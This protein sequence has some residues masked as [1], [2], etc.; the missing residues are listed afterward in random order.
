MIDTIIEK[1]VQYLA[2]PSVV[3]HESFFMEFLYKD[4]KSL[5][6]SAFKH[7]GV[8]EI[9]GTANSE[10]I[11]CAHIDRHGLISLGD[12][13]Y[14]YAAQ[15]IKEIKYGENNQS[16]R[17]IMESIAKR[18]E[19]EKIYAYHP[20]TGKVLANGIIE[21]CYPNMR[22]DDALFY[23]EG[24]AQLEQNIPLAY[25]RQASY[26][27]GILKGQ[28]DNVISIAVIYALFKAGYQGT[29]LLTCEEEIGKS[30]VHIARHLEG[31]HIETDRLIVLDT[32]P[33]NEQGIIEKGPVIFRNRDKNEIFNKDFVD[34]LKARC[35][36]TNTPYMIK[37]EILLAEG[38]EIEDLGSTELG[39]LVQNTDEQ[40]NGAT[41]Q[42]PTLMY[43]T[44]NE[45]TTTKAIEN[46]Y[47][48]L[49]NI[50]IEDRI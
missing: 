49:N 20:D 50:L 12:D 46:F 47:G 9:Y 36:K 1:T 6:L 30:W 33:F 27:R 42:I 21:A 35:E 10:N 40:W 41:V 29:A 15:Y 23:V 2:V 34:T 26:E 8:L 18:F 39:K 22:N 37:D 28:I 32:S 14:V 44:S 17:K 43:H 11:I 38:K 5:G 48:F 25:S 24:I 3:G 7:E 13:E 4:F 19:S 16:S 45:T 31:M